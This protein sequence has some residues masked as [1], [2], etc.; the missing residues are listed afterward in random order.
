MLSSARR[1][2][3]S[4]R[5][6]HLGKARRVRAGKSAERRNLEYGLGPV[7]TSSMGGPL[8]I[9]DGARPIT[10]RLLATFIEYALKGCV[11]WDEARRFMNT[12]Y[13]DE[14]MEHAKREL[15]RLLPYY[16]WDN[17]VGTVAMQPV[18]HENIDQLLAIASELRAEP[19]SG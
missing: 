8:V 9:P 4:T 10:R 5:A 19:G 13:D 3:R 18:P 16:C 17:G 14:L 1:A 2:R 11:T 7:Y 6:A 15:R 12:A